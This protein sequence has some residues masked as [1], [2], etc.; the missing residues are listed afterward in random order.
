MHR[1]CQHNFPRMLNEDQKAIRM[2]IAGYLISAFNKD[3]SLL[4]RI[5]YWRREMVFFHMTPNPREHQ[6][7]GSHHNLHASRNSAKIALKGGSCQRCSSTSRALCIQ[8]LPLKDALRTKNSYVSC[9]IGVSLSGRNQNCGLSSDGC[10]CMKTLL[11][12]DPALL[13]KCWKC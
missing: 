3:P 13:L 11:H 6:Q 1:V 2:E 9:V 12:T 10:F 7:H 5:L 8:N 4:G